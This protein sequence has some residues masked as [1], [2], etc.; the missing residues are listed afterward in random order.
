[1]TSPD[2]ASTDARHLTSPLR[3]PAA[4]VLLGANA[5]FLFVG[6]LQLLLTSRYGTFTGRAGAAFFAFVGIEAVV[7]PLLAVLLATHVRPVVP[8]AKLI[9]QVALGEYAASAGLGAL[10]FLIWTFG[11]L[12]EGE[13]LDAFLGLLVRLA[14]LAVLAVAAWAVYTI[15]RTRYHVPKPKP[16][17]GVYGQPH[18]GWPAGS[19]WSVPG[20]PGGPSAPGQH[21]G[22]PV[23]GQPG[24]YPAPGQ[25]GWPGSQ[26]GQPYPGVPQPGP[27]G[28][29]VPP[30]T[31]PPANPAPPFGPPPANPAPPFGPPPSADPTQAIPRQPADPREDEAGRTQ[32][33][34]PDDPNHPR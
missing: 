31:P 24:A 3:E 22:P 5:V 1:M 13:A 6:L 15:W 25:P 33:V 19:G 34:N 32:R 7:L 2:P 10:T 28:N 29:P 11:R 18:P 23:P 26:Y 20:Q 21:G 30:F 4:L 16:Q 8:R 12:A 17:P 9:T 14:W 27:T